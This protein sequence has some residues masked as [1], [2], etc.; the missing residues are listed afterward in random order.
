MCDKDA[1]DEAAELCRGEAKGQHHEVT[2]RV[3]LQARVTFPGANHESDDL[4]E[5]LD[6]VIDRREIVDWEEV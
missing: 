4:R 1:R 3:T 2:M 6:E 5:H